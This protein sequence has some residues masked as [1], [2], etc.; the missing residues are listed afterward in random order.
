M[1]HPQNGKTHCS[2]ITSDKDTKC[3]SGWNFKDK[4]NPIVETAKDLVAIGWSTYDSCY[5]KIS[6]ETKLTLRISLIILMVVK[7]LHLV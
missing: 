5:A 1:D 6:G 7:F 3:P 2:L 4:D